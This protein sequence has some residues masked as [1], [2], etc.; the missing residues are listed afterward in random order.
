MCVVQ[1]NLRL[2]P[3]RSASSTSIRVRLS[4]RHPVPFPPHWLCRI[5]VSPPR[6]IVRVLSCA[7][8]AEGPMANPDPVGSAG[9]VRRT[10][11]FMGMNDSETVAL[12]GGGHGGYLLFSTLRIANHNPRL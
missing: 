2:V 3:P 5:V 9:E 1:A 4:R 8:D 10:F 11:A 6:V 7:C 12:I